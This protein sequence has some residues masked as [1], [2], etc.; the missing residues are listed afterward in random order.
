M[1]CFNSNE[2]KWYAV[3]WETVDCNENGICSPGTQ[4]CDYWGGCCHL[5]SA[6]LVSRWSYLHFMPLC[7]QCPPVLPV[8]LP[9]RGRLGHLQNS[10]C[11]ES[12]PCHACQGKPTSSNSF[13]KSQL[14]RSK[15]WKVS[16]LT[17]E[18]VQDGIIVF[19]LPFMDFFPSKGT[20]GRTVILP[21]SYSS[22]F[23]WPPQICNWS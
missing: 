23:L 7:P 21:H 19:C 14:C 15:C 16:A 18:H 5:G 9:R 20:Q 8:P 17:G 11:T 1:A 3:V 10:H 22:P 12:A 2:I 4:L 13:N 6:R